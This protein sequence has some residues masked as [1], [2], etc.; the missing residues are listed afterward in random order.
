MAE[1]R[2][3]RVKFNWTGNWQPSKSYLIDD[4]IKFGGNSYVAVV[5]HTSV[6]STADF[7][8]TDFAKWNVHLEGISNTGEWAP[9]YLYKEN[10]VFKFGNVQYRVVVSHLSH[11]SFPDLSKV[12]EYV[13]GFKAEGEWNNNTQYQTGDVVNYQ[14]SSYVALTTSLAG[15]L[16]PI[17]VAIGTDVAGKSWQ[18]L[19]DGLAGA[20][21][22]FTPGT[23]YRGQLVQY[24]G[25][26]FRHKLG[27]TT[28][29][30]PLGSG[31]PVTGTGIG[32]SAWELLVQGFKFV[33]NFSTTFNY[34]VGH[35]ARFGSNSYVAV[36]NSFINIDPL[37]GL[38]T[39]WETLAAGDS[40]AALTTKGD[41]LTYNG[42]PFRIGIGSTGYALAVNPDGL[43]GYQIVG[44]QT[45][46]YYVD[47]ESGDDGSNGLAPNLAFKT[48]KQACQAARPDRSI[49]NFEYTASTGL[50]TITAPGHGL[51][52]VGTFVQLAE[53]EFECTSGG[54]TYGVLGF[55]YTPT[56]GIATV[57][58]INIGLAPETGIGNLLR[59]RDVQ[60]S[61]NTGAGSTTALF[62]N[63][64]GGS[65][66][67]ITAIP[68][69][70]SVALNVGIRTFSLNYIGGGTIFAGITTTIF[71][72]VASKSYFEVL[73]VLDTNRIVVNVGP[74]TIAHTYVGGGHITD[75]TP[76]VLRLSASQFYEQL[77]IIVPPFTSIVG[78]TLR[79]T[80]VLPKTGFS[81]DNSTPNNR[82]TMFQLSDATTIQALAFKGLEGFHYDSAAPFE[83]NNT[84]VR[85]GVGTTA[86]G[87][88]FA[89]NPNSPVNNKSPYVKDCTCFSDPASAD[90]RFGGGGVGVFLDGGVHEE[91]ARSMVFDSFTMVNSDGAGYILDKNAIAEIVSCFT[92]Y[93]K[94]G[95]YSGGGSRIRA[96]G[97]NNSYGDY[98]V[99]A[100]GFSTSEPVRSARLFGDLMK[101]QPATILG[102]V[103]VGQTM[104]GETSGAH[105]WL[106]NDQRAADKFHFKYYPGYG[107]TATTANGNIAIGTSPFIDGELVNTYSPTSGAGVAGSFYVGAASSSISGQKGTI[108]EVDAVSG[109]LL[110]GDSVGFKTTFGQESL[111]YI[112]NTITNVSAAQTFI[113]GMTGIAY[114]Y[115]NR[116]TLTISPDKSRATP[117]TRNIHPLGNFS[118]SVSAGSSIDVRTKFSQVRLTG[119]D[120][121]YVGTGNKTETN[122]PFVDETALQQG[123]ETR[124]FGPG[125][126]FFVSTDQ[127]GNFRVGQFFSVNQLTG[128]ATLDASAFNLSGLTELR[129]G[130][131][132]GQVG[133]SI[134]EF[135]SDEQMGGNSNS[136]CPTEFAVRGFL[137]RDKMGTGAM[138][139]PRGTTAQRPSG[140]D[141][142]FVAGALRFNLTNSSLEFYD[143]SKWVQP[144]KLT[145]NTINSATT[146]VAQNVY[147]VN[148][149]SGAITVTLPAN[150]VIG[151]TVRIYD[152]A[153]T[154]DNNALTVNRNG[155]LIQGDAQDLTVNI[156]GSAFDLT[157]S[158]DTWGWRIFSI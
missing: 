126:V 58:A 32:N 59:V 109:T 121:L 119:H 101:M 41:I 15:F 68:S 81:D 73:Q 11:G 154:F 123:N 117:D 132:G 138:V 108:V 114:T 14:G 52:N 72:D 153:K 60:V 26:I 149:V 96:V 136:A 13:A 10:E 156:E 147:F 129:L 3:G 152:L 39:Y 4:I 86:C 76:A 74:S 45:R 65:N 48:I 87:K 103:A 158:N 27:V 104:V 143:G 69:N 31:D 122:Y 25:H 110:V 150:P 71:P 127:G 106:I 2:L 111:F 36:G 135:S 5:N 116:A 91:G 30:Y 29:V 131:I 43:P 63:A 85:T 66:F 88:F 53:I 100:S 37:A 6:A 7:Y 83:I 56:T 19:A 64:F 61:Y 115:Y 75:L 35:V 134:N 70:N 20:A 133:E 16:P 107:A 54:N 145:Y 38:G 120:F 80:T 94:W 124:T 148:T 44:A 139:P 77:P 22:T 125:K 67:P 49:T 95:Y 141:A 105:G 142:S 33:G 18:I 79:G 118:T 57:T 151:D 62:A 90:G 21:I 28:S 92:Y 50:S 42:G 112:I 146:L 140:L 99:I 46:V 82:A 130:A 1:F 113:D 9:N 17:N 157:F 34:N 84:N 51:A 78:H 47:S 24:G 144:G 55:N 102:T 93:C 23:Y 97:G 12:V 128:R 155:K 98:G 40:S 8:V 137:L 89:L